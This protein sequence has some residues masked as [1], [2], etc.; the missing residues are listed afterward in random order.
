MK[1]SPWSRITGTMG[2]YEGTPIEKLLDY[3]EHIPITQIFGSK[4][5][6]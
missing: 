3:I 2:Y 6:N 4:R 5:R 1:V